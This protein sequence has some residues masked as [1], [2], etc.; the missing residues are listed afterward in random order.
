MS[1]LLT[2][3]KLSPT[4]TVGTIAKWHVH[5]GEKIAS[6]ALLLDISTDKATIEHYALDGGWLRRIVIPEGGEAEVNQAIALFT[7]TENEDISNWTPPLAPSVVAAAKEKEQSAKAGVSTPAEGVQEGQPPAKTGVPSTR[8][9]PR[10]TAEP[11]LTPS[12]WHFAPARG[13]VPAH[14]VASPLARKLAKEQNLDLASVQ[15]SGPS[16]RVVSGDLKLAQPLSRPS[17]KRFETPQIPPGSFHLI[18]LSPM[19]KVIGK[20]LQESKSFIPHFYVRQT[21]SADQLVSMRQQLEQAGMKLTF[22]DFILRGVALTLR[23]MPEM[24]RGFDS[25]EQAMIQFETVDVS[26]AVGFPEGLITPILRHADYKTLS[27]LSLE[28]KELSKR[29]KE[30]DLLPHEYQGGSF[31]ISNLG[32]YG[33]DDFLPVINPPQAAILGVGAIR[34]AAVVKGGAVVCG[35][36]MT[37]VLAADHRVVDGATGADFMRRLRQVLENPAMLIL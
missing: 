18:P 25:A 31:T 21:L 37:L 8:I 10:F 5:E 7:E 32:M 26:V 1:F 35:K 33:V 2:M 36:E 17:A 23:A 34:D 20:R 24:N 27:E 13:E 6:G 12:Q 3:P 15:G 11:P 28:M 4:M 9:E 30:G 16:G 29:A 19:R 14:V 22:N